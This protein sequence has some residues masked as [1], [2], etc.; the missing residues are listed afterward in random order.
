MSRALKLDLL[1]GMR[2]VAFVS[3]VM[4][5]S[6]FIVSGWIF[7]SNRLHI[8]S[9]L[10]TNS[11]V[12]TAKL[13]PNVT[14]SNIPSNDTAGPSSPIQLTSDPADVEVLDLLR[15]AVVRC[16]II[17]VLLVVVQIVS[18]AFVLGSSGQSCRA[19]I[20]LWFV[21]NAGINVAILICLAMPLMYHIQHG[22]HLQNTQLDM[23]ESSASGKGETT[24]TLSP[25]IPRIN[26]LNSFYI[27]LGADFLVQFVTLI[28]CLLL[29]R[30]NRHGR[31]QYEQVEDAQS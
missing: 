5:I 14:E 1:N 29:L 24:R 9:K 26:H 30:F 18:A 19:R 17:V 31:L 21:L 15:D 23:D 20:K 25:D 4:G 12:V 28:S 11:V 22:R 16:S 7:L 8:D 10:F 27:G 3:F 2:V 6:T 13:K